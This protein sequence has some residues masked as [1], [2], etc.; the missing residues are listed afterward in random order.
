[1]SAL[2][3]VGLCCTGYMVIGIV[4]WI[5]ILKVGSTMDKKE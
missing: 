4:F 5:T 3:I 2:E 1:M